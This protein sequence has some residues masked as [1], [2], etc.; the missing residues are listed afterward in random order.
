MSISVRIDGLEKWR[1]ICDPERFRQEI[2]QPG[3][4]PA[5]RSG[6]L[7]RFPGL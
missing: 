4:V 7:M 5:L 2:A 6:Y 1:T 3:D